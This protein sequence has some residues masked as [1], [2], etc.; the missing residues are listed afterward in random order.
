MSEVGHFRTS[1]RQPARSA[2]PPSTDIVSAAAHV[3]KVPTTEVAALLDHLVAT[4]EVPWL[5][6]SFGQPGSP[7]SFFVS[8]KVG[9]PKR[10]QHVFE[11][12]NT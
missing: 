3:R 1:L 11:S 9:P 10:A 8:Q 4:G 7:Q 5:R 6:W 12:G 2:S